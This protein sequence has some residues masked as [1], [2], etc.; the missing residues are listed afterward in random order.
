MRAELALTSNLDSLIY[1]LS[2]LKQSE[3]QSNDLSGFFREDEDELKSLYV[4][5]VAKEKDY[6]DWEVASEILIP[7]KMIF[8]QQVLRESTKDDN[9]AD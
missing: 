6:R 4:N 2:E 8:D 5:Y 1:I 7:K 3:D 9:V